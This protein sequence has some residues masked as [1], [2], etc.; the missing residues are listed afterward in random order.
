MRRI[1]TELPG[2]ALELADRAAS[3]LRGYDYTAVRVRTVP[4]SRAPGNL[5]LATLAR[6]LDDAAARWA[7]E[8][9]LLAATDARVVA[10]W[11]RGPECHAAMIRAEAAALGVL[12]PTELQRRRDTRH[13]AQRARQGRPGP[14]IVAAP[15][16][17]WGRLAVALGQT[18]DADTPMAHG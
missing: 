10:V 7:R 9:G 15:R 6:L 16:P 17:P 18:G 2:W 1:H 13:R 14:R 3:S 5:E 12:D 11:E 4:S 8:L